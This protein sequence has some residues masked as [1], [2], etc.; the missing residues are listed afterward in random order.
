MT[1]EEII[2]LA[3]QAGF[4]KYEAWCLSGKSDDDRLVTVEEYPVGE[5]V[6]EFASLIAKAQREACAKV[7]ADSS[8]RGDDMGA[9]LARKIHRMGDEA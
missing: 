7:C 9:I 3:L 5:A 1:K 8:L 2:R 4:D 6:L